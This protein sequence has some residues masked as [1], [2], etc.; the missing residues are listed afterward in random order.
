MVS[1]CKVRVA[2]TVWYWL[3]ER[4]TDP[5]NGTEN[6]KQPHTFFEFEI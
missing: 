2:E 1:I 6:R 4:H 5:R 3:S